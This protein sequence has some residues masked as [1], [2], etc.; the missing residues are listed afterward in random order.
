MYRYRCKNREC[1]ARK[2]LKKLKEQ[3]AIIPLCHSCRKDT[4]R[5]DMYRDKKENKNPCLCDGRMFPHRKGEKECKHRDWMK[6]IGDEL[7]AVELPRTK[8]PTF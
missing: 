5:R 3:Y 7:G 8:E 4:L 2:S 1:R 6:I